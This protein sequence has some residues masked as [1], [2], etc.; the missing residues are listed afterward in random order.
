LL[1]IAASRSEDDEVA[2]D[3]YQIRTVCT[4]AP[5]TGGRTISVATGADLQR[6]L[7]AAAAGDVVLLQ[8]GVVYRPSAQ[9]G[10]FMLRNRGI[11]AGQWV[12]VRSAHSAF[13]PRGALQS[14]T[15]VS[16]SNAGLMPQIRAVRT[17]MPAIRAE[18]GARGYRLIGLDIAPDTSVQQLSNLVELG[19]GSETSLDELPANIIIDRSYLHGNDSGNFRRGVAMN[20][21]HLAVLDSYVA[22]FHDG[23]G[24]SQA[25][26]G[27]NG[28]GPFKIVNNYLEAAS[29]NVLFGGSD[30]AI[31]GLVPSD[32]EIR[33][34]LS[35]KRQEWRDA[36]V[37][38]KNAFELKNA[39][40][41]LVEGNVFERVWPSGQDG[42]AILLK[43]VNQDGKCPWCV[44]EYVTFRRNIVRSASHGVTINAVEVG[45]RGAE[46]PVPANH[47][48][49]EDVV[50]EDLTGKLF[51]IFG[52]VSDV[53]IV[54]VT[55][56][57][58]PSGVL[59]A[60]DPADHNPNLVFKFNI[61][62]RKTYG[63]GTGGDEGSKTLTRNFAPFTY[64][65]NILVN[66]SSDG[67]QPV[68][69]GTLESRYPPTTW[70]VR[71]WNDVG[72]QA[73]TSKLA[74]SSRFASAAE[75]GHDVGADVDAIAAAQ[76]GSGRSGDGCGPTAVPR[77]KSG[78]RP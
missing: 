73:G 28:G 4:P 22:N 6:A 23:N 33:R 54:H 64:R 45:R 62:E 66:T 58:N 27:W 11:P 9:D 10:S 34:N 1:P 69:D 18:R 46:N 55:S 44:T 8:P 5:P 61:V 3:P 78:R 15:R 35:T 7:D 68:S 43:S 36:R 41:V 63:V 39:R 50:F 21:M 49:F 57:S 32:I 14:G 29:E 72:F 71:G 48:R 74:K 47:I 24:D 77:P 65:Q 26:G 67:E 16:E 31:P 30:P 17:N 52:G 42:T 19:N 13:D 53:S 2:V 75:D 56:R 76:T 20:G 70:V 60:R 40:R 38:V 37:P 12:T 25:I 51:R 59:E